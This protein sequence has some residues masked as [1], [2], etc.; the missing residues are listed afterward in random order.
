MSLKKALRQSRDCYILANS[1]TP[2]VAP[3]GSTQTLWGG[4]LCSLIVSSI[5]AG[6]R[7]IIMHRGVLSSARSPGSIMQVLN[8]PNFRWSCLLRLPGAFHLISSAWRKGY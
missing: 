4:N 1:H 2:P 6:V 7:E 8:P 5:L 3:L